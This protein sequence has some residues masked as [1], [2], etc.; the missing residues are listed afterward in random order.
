M[1]LVE[2]RQDTNRMEGEMK[3]PTM[4]LHS[5]RKGVRQ[6]YWAGVHIN[7]YKDAKMWR[8]ESAMKIPGEQVLA[9]GA[10]IDIT[11][12]RVMEELDRRGYGG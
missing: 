12:K 1:Q 3:A 9:T 7:F 4:K 2:E 6:G 5:I 10:T 11:V 8:A